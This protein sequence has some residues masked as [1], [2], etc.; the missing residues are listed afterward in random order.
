MRQ[1]AYTV[2]ARL[3]AGYSILK[4][5]LPMHSSPVR[6]FTTGLPRILVRLA[7]VRRAASV[8]SEPGSNSQKNIDLTRAATSTHLVD[9]T[10]Q[11]EIVKELLL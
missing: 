7:C 9:C 11:Y 10:L 4:G 8:R 1:Q 2:L 5:R 6:H 3:S